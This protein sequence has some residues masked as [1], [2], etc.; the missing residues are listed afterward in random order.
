MLLTSSPHWPSQ[1]ISLSSHRIGFAIARRLAQD[2]A[3]VL[4]SSRKQQNVDQAVAELQG[5][6]LN[7]AGTVC[8]VGKAEDRERLVTTVSHKDMGTE[9]GGGRREPA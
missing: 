4:V 6:G 8:H 2:G 3:R 1:S 5:E 9:P 7:V